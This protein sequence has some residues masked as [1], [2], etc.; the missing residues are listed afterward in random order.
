MQG[1]TGITGVM[2]LA[3]AASV[4]ERKRLEEST[5]RLVALVESSYDAIIGK[6]TDGVIVSWNRSAERLYG[7]TAE[8]AIGKHIGMLIPPGREDELPQILGMIRR[9][10]GVRQLETVRQR[11]DGT[12]VD[13]SLMVSPVRDSQG[14]I[15]GASAIARDI[16]DRKQTEMMLREA[17]QKLTAWVSRLERQTQE[18]TLLNQMIR[19]LQTCQDSAEVHVVV[20]QFAEQLFPADSGALY[21]LNA[22][23]GL[24]EM[25]SSWGKMPPAA[26]VFS[27]Q[28]CWALRRGQVHAICD[29][30]DP[31]ACPHLVQDSPVDSLC[32]PMIAQGE[33][34]GV[35]HLHR[36]TLDAGQSPDVRARLL[37]S[38]EQ[39]AVTVAGHVALALANLNLRDT[40]RAQSIRDPLTG[41]YNRRYLSESLEREVRRTLR[42]QRPLAVVMLDVDYFKQFNDTLGHDAGDA[43]LHALGGYLQSRTRGEDIACRY[44]GDEFVIVLADVSMETMLR[45]A[46]QLQEGIKHLTVSYGKEYL[47]APTVSL[48]VAVCP[49]HG[50][51]AEALLQAADEAL[52]KAKLQGRDRV[53]VGKTEEIA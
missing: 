8:E 16:S 44:G 34:L 50:S 21:A 35:V 14:N 47:N 31:L 5:S 43:L 19:L 4:S 22:S 49:D 24:I 26:Q 3:V 41:L 15:V 42:S 33:T 51:S 17:N 37:A 20:R 18:I 13:I 40:L 6:S 10:E 45:R 1:V 39:L 48:G 2:A 23:V 53:V 7:Y 32:A 28:E 38:R 46:H 11:K 27:S 36:D 25:V 29:A 30:Q 52:Y 9:N 12:T